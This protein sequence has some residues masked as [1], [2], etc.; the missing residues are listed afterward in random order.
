MKSIPSYAFKGCTGLT[1][2]E[3]PNSI[4][5]IG[6]QAF[7]NCTWLK[8][9]INFS[10]LTFSKGSSSNGYVAYYATKVINAPN[11]VI[12]G[13]FIWYENEDGMTLAGYLGNAT[14]ITLPDNYN[15]E[16]YTIGNSAFSYCDGLKSITMPNSVISI[17]Y[18]A[19]R[20]CTSLTSVVI[21][22]SVT[23]IGDRAFSGCSGLKTVYN[24]SNLTFSKGTS[25]NGYV[26]YYADKVYNAPNGLFE[27][28]FIFGKPNDV[29]TLV[30][31]L[32]N[33][34][35]LTLPA[36]Y[37]GENYAIGAAAFQNYTGL[38][39]E[40]I[41]HNNITGIGA[42]AFKGCN[43]IEKLYIGS[44][45]ESIGDKAFAGCEKINEIKVALEKPIR[46]SADIFADAVYDNATLYI[47]NGTEQLYQKREP[48]NMFFYIV[49]IDFTGIEDV[50]DEEEA[51]C[52]RVQTIYDLQ[53]RKVE[54]PSEGLYIINGK[55]VMIK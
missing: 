39:A 36:G 31:Y 45:V 48:W 32:G 42:S 15:G 7:K 52:E 28:D 33:A 34:T 11:A 38:A 41:I 5:S 35:E 14:E 37:N 43:N 19:F 21:P 53:G 50:Y 23:S 51:E 22:N 40:L 24:F 12:D 44:S 17:G 2:I 30:G 55:K 1:S 9:V 16:N 18:E 4:T 29:N 3:I 8:T 49:E 20:G 26:A 6:N 54:V 46:G 47:P 10:N 25:S 27:G 13:D